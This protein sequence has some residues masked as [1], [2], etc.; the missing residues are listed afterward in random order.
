MADTQLTHT[1][2][3][4]TKVCDLFTRAYI[5]PNTAQTYGRALQ[6]YLDWLAGRSPFD[7]TPDEQMEWAL[8]YRDHVIATFGKSTSATYLS[9]IKSFH[10]LAKGI[11]MTPVNVWE[12][13]KVPKPQNT[14][15]TEAASPDTLQNAYRK[16]EQL[17]PRDL[18]V[19]RLLYEAALRRSEVAGLP[20]TALCHSATEGYYLSVT[21]K[22]EK[23]GVIG[24]T[25]D[26]AQAIQQ[27]VLQHPDSPWLFPGYGGEHITTRTVNRIVEAIDPELHPH[28]LR[29][30]HATEA[31]ESGE[32]IVI[33]AGTLRHSSIETTRRYL[34]RRDAISKST[35]RKIGR[36]K[37]A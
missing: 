18:L 11:G 32:D 10:K 19:F 1:S 2:Q 33:I 9:A 5:Q 20:A 30:T 7:G 27:E 35:A 8:Q 25:D 22:G 3:D 34:H 26:L 14:S 36:K 17:G 6:H 15:K 4:V 29:H 37:G 28:K 12:L 16:A 21:G 13:V 24:I 23:T 31:S